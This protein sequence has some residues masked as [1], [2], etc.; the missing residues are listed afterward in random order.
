MAENWLEM[1]VKWPF[2]SV[3]NLGDQSLL[4][5]YCRYAN[6]H[7]SIKSEESTAPRGASKYTCSESDLVSDESELMPPEVDEKLFPKVK[8]SPSAS[9]LM[10]ANSLPT[11]S[12][13]LARDELNLL[14]KL[15]GTDVIADQQGSKGTFRINLSD[16]NDSK[17]TNTL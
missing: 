6:G 17:D 13:D 1:V 4:F 11:G 9:D 2:L 14:A 16:L 5:Y 7:P 10:S 12:S 15:I 8:I 3:S